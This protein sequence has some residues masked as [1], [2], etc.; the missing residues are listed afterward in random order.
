VRKEREESDIQE[1]VKDSERVERYNRIKQ[2]E[3]RDRESRR[4]EK[5]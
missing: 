4:K 2:R 3:T 5:E 1:C